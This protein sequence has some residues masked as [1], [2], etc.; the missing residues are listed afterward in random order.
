MFSYT[1]SAM[2]SLTSVQTWTDLEEI[3]MRCPQPA[4]APAVGQSGYFRMTM[5]RG[6]RS[7]K[8]HAEFASDPG[9]YGRGVYWAATR[10]F[11]EIYGDEIICDEV[12]LSNALRLDHREVGTV[13]RER[14]I[15]R[16]EDGHEARL[17]AA[18]AFTNEMRAL[19]YDGIVVEGYEQPGLWSAC[20]FPAVT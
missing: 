9:D 5:Y 11:A 1:Y 14:G 19:G 3:V 18:E 4:F 15:T 16:M 10:E 6:I 17:I 8:L 7:T 12:C 13:A 2:L 20:V